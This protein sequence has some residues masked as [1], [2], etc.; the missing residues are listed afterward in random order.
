LA[1][2]HPRSGHLIWSISWYE[3]QFDHLLALI[4]FVT[5]R[6][7]GERCHNACGV[8]W[9]GFWLLEKPDSQLRLE[10]ESCHLGDR[11]GGVRD[12]GDARQRDPR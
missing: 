1:P 12:P 7:H 10:L 8:Q 2:I 11:A 4:G 5:R 6:R 9:Q 3:S